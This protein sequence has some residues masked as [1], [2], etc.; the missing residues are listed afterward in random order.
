MNPTRESKRK[1]IRGLRKIT[2]EFLFVTE[3]FETGVAGI[4]WGV[5]ICDHM[6]REYFVRAHEKMEEKMGV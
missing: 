3:F 2:L 1:K 5:A 6:R 4:K